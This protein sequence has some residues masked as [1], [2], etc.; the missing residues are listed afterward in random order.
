MQCK[1]NGAQDAICISKHIPVPGA[2]DSISQRFKELGP[3]CVVF[4]LFHVLT[5]VQLNHQFFLWRAEIHDV[6][7]DGMLPSKTDPIEFVAAQGRPKFGFGGGWF[8]AQS[9]GAFVPF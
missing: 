5:S 4:F 6:L 9:A 8:F 1:L 7:T 3:F 2:H